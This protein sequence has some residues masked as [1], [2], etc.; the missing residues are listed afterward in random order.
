MRNIAQIILVAFVIITKK[1]LLIDFYCKKI[2]NYSVM[3]VSLGVVPRICV[4]GLDTAKIKIP[5]WR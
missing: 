4:N 5:L 3:A 1:I 2:Y